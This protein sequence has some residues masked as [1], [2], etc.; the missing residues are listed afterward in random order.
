MIAYVYAADRKSER[1]QAH[2]GDFADILQLD[3]YG[4]Y[5]G[6]GR[7]SLTYPATIVAA[8]RAS[9]IAWASLS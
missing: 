5:T 7:T 9:G 1:A 4:G 8:Q 2:L 3:G 6:A